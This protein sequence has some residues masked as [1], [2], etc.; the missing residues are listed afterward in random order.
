MEMERA[1]VM[2]SAKTQFKN[3]VTFLIEDIR[4]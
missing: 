4:Q 1:E 2:T 3:K